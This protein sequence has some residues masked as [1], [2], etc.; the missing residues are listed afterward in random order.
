MRNFANTV[1]I[2]KHKKR[3]LDNYVIYIVFVLYFAYFVKH[4]R[5]VRGLSGACV[6]AA[7][8]VCE[9]KNIVKESVPRKSTLLSN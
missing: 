9:K 8:D 3:S 6:S 7:R 2:R 5:R 4:E 1:F